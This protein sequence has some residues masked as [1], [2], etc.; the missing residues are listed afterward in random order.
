MP[1]TKFSRYNDEQV[2][3]VLVFMGFIVWLGRY[4]LNKFSQ[5]CNATNW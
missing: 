2:N 1:A 4:T 3:M 5:K